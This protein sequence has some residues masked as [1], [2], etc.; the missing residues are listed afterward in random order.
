MLDP[1]KAFSEALDL[2]RKGDLGA[3]EALYGRIIKLQP[4]HFDTLHLFGMLRCQQGRFA[5]GVALIGAALRRN[6]DFPPAL[7]NYGRAL[8][9][10]K[11]PEEAL[12]AFERALSL[13]P[14]QAE[15]FYYR[16]MV[17]RGLGRN[18]EAVASFDRAMAL[19]PNYPE[20]LNNRG[21]ALLGLQRTAD[22]LASFEHAVA[23]RPDYVAAHNN[24]GNTLLELHRLDE[25]LESYAAALAI[26]PDHAQALYN[27][28]VALQ[29]LGR[30]LEA[31]DSYDRLLRINP[32]HVDALNNRGVVLRGQKRAP[33]AL[34]SF[35]RALALVPD[36]GEALNNRGLA[37][38]D[39][40]RPQEALASHDRAL[41]LRPN[42]PDTLC[43]RGVA[44]RE[45]RRH[46][47]ALESFE[48]A[49]A[50]D[51][52]HPYAF[53]GMA[54]AALAVCDWERT[55]TI[56]RELAERIAHD[57]SSITP[58]T[59]LGYSDDYALQLA[60]ATGAVANE[61]PQRLQPLWRGGDRRRD[62]IR[63]A[64]LSADF[65]EHATALLMAGLFE[66]HDRDRFEVI[67]VSYG[68]DDGSGMRA[69][70]VRAFDQFHDVQSMDDM[71]V[72]NLLHE[73]EVDIAVDLKGHT[74]HSRLGIL[75]YRPAPVQV[76]YLG[77]PGT[78]GADFIDYVIADEIV[79]PFD[80]QPFFTERIV[81]LPDCY[82]VN[83]SKRDIAAETPSRREAGLPEKGFVF[84]CFNASYKITAPLF[85]IWMRL[86]Q[87]VDGSALWLLHDN[88][89]AVEN[90]R[91]E[92]ARRGVEPERLVF[93]ARTD[94]AG[95][96]ARLRL[97]DLCL[98]TL[99]YN[100]HTT[101]SDALWV[102]V[103]LVT[104]T[105][106]SFAGR[107]AT[108]L[109]HAVGLPELAAKD[110]IEYEALA[111]RLATDPSLLSEF[112]QRLAQNGSTR[113]LFD[114][115]GFCRHLESAY[116][117]M[118]EILKRGEKPRGFAVTG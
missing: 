29:R 70:V 83:D 84:C 74:Q 78:T 116:T 118:W 56:A 16:A 73:R 1:S 57:R 94:P 58:F 68:R 72:A 59:L 18:A 95:H 55:V 61:A 8:D 9:A 6:P 87:A 117:T 38:R 79:L 97:A 22:A 25:A 108:S 115:A 63:I 20:A 106:R 80:Q 98:D 60:A 10:L 85:D 17:L 50:L 86:L 112:R 31:L 53:A 19:R 13:E 39:L 69:R 101:G 66:L 42:D 52:S 102:G 76:T 100:A 23:M 45:L 109:L 11:R 7:V 110:L 26:Q 32:R 14:N 12:A 41:A 30:P 114:T 91:R 99:P 113:S 3:A 107:V 67:G 89:A 75:A 81:H 48:R 4:D 27:R 103:P 2:H 24:R 37:L 35:D 46:G 88:D 43:G 40:H 36:H 47:E 77:Y 92:A 82:Q 65:H 54:D 71:G 51:P 44:L 62:K 34:A 33:E 104:A 21:L 28:G 5:E 49:L 15:A 96:L 93:A 90:L 64:Y 111:L 105:G